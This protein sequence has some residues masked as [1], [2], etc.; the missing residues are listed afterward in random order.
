[1]ELRDFTFKNYGRLL[2]A[3]LEAGWN[4]VSV[5]EYLKSED[6]S[7]PFLILR[8]D[9]DRRVRNARRMAQFESDYGVSSTYYFR[10]K[11]FSAASASRIEDM[12]HEIGYHYEDVAKA[13]GDLERA[14]ERF[15]ENLRNFRKVVDIDTA[16]SHGS[17]LS[18][19]HN[20]DIWQHS[21]SF[22][23]YGLLGEAYISLGIDD[24]NRGDIDYVSDTHRTWRTSP[25]LDVETTQ[26][27][28]E[29]L[30]NHETNRLCV[31]A[32]P[33]RWAVNRLQ[34]VERASWDVCAETIKS[35]VNYYFEVRTALT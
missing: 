2:D 24:P 32:H 16:A 30:R 3:G 14:H 1:M 33:N 9:V 28:I 13:D 22:E 5:R 10:V 34:L 4:I 27:L 7:E 8:H 12:G 29:V 11:T 15:A 18:S 20:L 31:L 25:T 26:D 21:L 19:H 6:P 23:D 35:V 17:A